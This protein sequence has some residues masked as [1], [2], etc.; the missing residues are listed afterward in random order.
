MLGRGTEKIKKNPKLQKVIEENER[1]KKYFT[2][3]KD[4]LIQIP[5][6]LNL[7]SPTGRALI[8]VS[9]AASSN[10]Q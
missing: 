6:D 5:E 4:P 1:I 3:V 8:K 7:D 9:A 2:E 10:A